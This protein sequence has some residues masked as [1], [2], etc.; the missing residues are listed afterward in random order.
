M[1]AFTRVLREMRK[2]PGR[3]VFFWI[4][5]GKVLY[6]VVSENG[7]FFLMTLLLSGSS[8]REPCQCHP[9][10]KSCHIDYLP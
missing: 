8:V 10:P 4:L 3:V 5:V 2:V 6:S 9:A 7:T 1:G